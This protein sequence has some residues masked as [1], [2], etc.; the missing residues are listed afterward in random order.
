MLFEYTNEDGV[1]TWLAA[2][3]VLRVESMGRLGATSGREMA[4][5]IDQKT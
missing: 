3:A 1:T 2:D 4:S 5:V